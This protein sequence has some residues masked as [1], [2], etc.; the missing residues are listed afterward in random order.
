MLIDQ[1]KHVL[2]REVLESRPAVIFIGSRLARMIVFARR[3][4]SS[5]HRLLSP[6]RL[7]LFGGMQFIESFEKQ[8]IS[9]LL[10]DFERVR[11][12]ARPKRIPNTVN[13]VTNFA[14]Q[15]GGRKLTEF[16]PVSR[17]SF[18]RNA[19]PPSSITARQ[20]S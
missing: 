7:E 11:D 6:I 18:S 19:D 17:G 2:R 14:G 4:D 9:D 13:L 8:E 5:L 15:H 20:E 1:I 3:K 12:S 16:F 10:N